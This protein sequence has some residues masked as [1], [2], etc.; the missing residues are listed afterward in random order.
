MKWILETIV[1]RQGPLYSLTVTPSPI[2]CHMGES[3]AQDLVSFL[4]ELDNQEEW[5]RRVIPI[6]IREALETSPEVGD[7]DL[8]QWDFRWCNLRP[9]ACVLWHSMCGTEHMN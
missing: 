7:L 6:L 4:N 8:L 9:L 3:I 5:D 2:L 1:A